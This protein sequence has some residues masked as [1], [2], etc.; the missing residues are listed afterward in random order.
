[1]SW[2]G[3]EAVSALAEEICEDFSRRCPA[4]L[5]EAGSGPSQKKY[6]TALESTDRAIRAFL[7]KSPAP[8]LVKK[9]VCANKV[10]WGLTE[11]GYAK[12]VAAQ[13]TERVVLGLTRF[14]RK[15]QA[16]GPV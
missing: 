15:P 12:D 16:A 4:E 1:M 5:L 11:R 6:Q 14:P 10:R 7:L 8:G 3:L 9:A 2:L 13:V